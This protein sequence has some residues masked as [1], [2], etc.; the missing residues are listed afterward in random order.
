MTETQEYQ[1][2][3][4]LVRVNAADITLD[5]DDTVE[6]TEDEAIAINHNPERDEP[7]LEPVDGDDGGEA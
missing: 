7:I 2:R 4:D 6:L 3:G 5:A 1:L